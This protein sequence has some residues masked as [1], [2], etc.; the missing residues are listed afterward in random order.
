MTGR[1]GLA[2]CRRSWP[3]RI[4]TLP[5]RSRPSRE[6]SSAVP[7]VPSPQP[8]LV[9]SQVPAQRGTHD[10]PTGQPSRTCLQAPLP[11]PGA[12]QGSGGIPL[13]VGNMAPGKPGKGSQ[14]FCPAR[15]CRMALRGTA[16]PST[17]QLSLFFSGTW[18]L[19]C[20]AQAGHSPMC[21]PVRT[22]CPPAQES[23]GRLPSWHRAQLPARAESVATGPHHGAGHHRGCTHI[24]ATTHTA[25]DTAQPWHRSPG[26]K[27]GTNSPLFCLRHQ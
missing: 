9:S 18:G 1:A 13:P 16:G 15:H 19:Q 26:A 24:W 11:S 4:L 23:A 5:G 8:S 20:H 27:S 12:R 7:A 2:P 6:T 14:A 25:L 21:L 22:G 10:S 3:H 17:P